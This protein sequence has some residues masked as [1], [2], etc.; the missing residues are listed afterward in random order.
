VVLD[1]DGLNA[2]A[3]SPARLTDREREAVLTPHRG[4]AARLGVGDGDALNAARD[5]VASTEAVTLIKGTRSVIAEPGGR[6]RINPTGTPV[7]ATAGTGDVLAGAIA[8][9]MA[10]GLVPFDAAWA[11]AYVHGLAG[12][13]AGR[14]RG[15]GATAS[16][17]ADRLPE[18]LAVTRSQA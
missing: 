8:G 15:E 2:F 3:G 14:D 18:A 1:A 6:A 5:L 4:E 13:F 17:V 11:G 12:I 16:D 10:R 7:L 9:L